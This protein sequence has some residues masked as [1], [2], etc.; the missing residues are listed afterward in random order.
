M[1]QDQVSFFNYFRQIV[2]CE[3]SQACNDT[4]VSKLWF[5]FFKSILG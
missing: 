2:I 5:F 4:M 3:K 1:P